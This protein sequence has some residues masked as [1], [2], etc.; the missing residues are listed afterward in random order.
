MEF[1][2]NK[3]Y[4]CRYSII[5]CVKEFIALAMIMAITT[6]YI[7]EEL[8]DLLAS[9]NP[10]QVLAFHTSSKAQKRLDDLLSKTKNPKGLSEVEKNE[11]EQ[12]MLVEHIVSLAKARALKR[13]SVASK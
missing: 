10:E 7:F 9:M 8:A 2:N 11:V 5:I 1:E 13:L 12:F 6:H 3:S 4:I